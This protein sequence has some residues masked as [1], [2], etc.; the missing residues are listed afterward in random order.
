[1][2]FYP[3]ALLT[4]YKQWA[5][6]GLHEV[7]ARNLDRL[8]AQDA[9]ILVR[10]LDHIH[11]VDRIFQHHLQGTP[12]AFS[13]PYSNDMPDFQRL[14]DA[15]ELVDDWYASYARALSADDLE[16]VV[17][18]VFTSGAPARMTRGEMILHV[19]LHGSSHRGTASFLL[20]KNGITPHKDR[21]TDFVERVV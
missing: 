15:V 3:Y 7:V 2:G 1:M 6:C 9:M 10:I 21:M 13:A 12:H 8:E 11:V 20:Q 18:F 5:D 19:C 17:E 16:Q 4:R 14:A